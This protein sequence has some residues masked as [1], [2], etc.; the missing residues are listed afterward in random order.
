[1]ADFSSF[2]LGSS[3]EKSK[4]SVEDVQNMIFGQESNFG[5]AKTDVPNYAGAIGPGQILPKTWAGLK[6][7]G[8]IP[9]SYDINVPEHNVAGSKALVADAYNRYGGDADKVL[10][11]YYAGP[12]VI[13]NGEI[14]TNWKDLK[15]PKAPNVGQYIEQ[16][17]SKLEGMGDSFSNFIMGGSTTKSEKT[18]PEQIATQQSMPKS[19]MEASVNANKELQPIA[20]VLPSVASLADVTVGSVL[21]FVGKQATY[22]VGR[23]LGQNPTEAEATSTKVSEFL[24]KPFGKA[25]GAT[26][27]PAYKTEASQQ[28]MN[29]IGENISKGAEWIAQKTGLP[30][31][32]VQNMIGTATIAAGKGVEI[33]AKPVAKAVGTFLKEREIPPSELQSQFE[34]KG[35]ANVGAAQV[36]N[37][38]IL[39]EAINRAQSPDLKAEFQTLKPKEINPVVLERHLEAD[40]LPIPI[41]LTKGQAT[42]D[43]KILSDEINSRAKNPELAYRY[44]EQNAQLIDNI[45]AIKENAAPDVYGTNHVENG[46]TLIDAYKIIDE[47][48]KADINL[49]YEALK[50]AAGG[51]FPIDG[52]AFANNAFK[53]LSKDLKSDFVPPAIEKQLKRF[54]EGEP[55]TF[56]QFESMRTNL[57]AEMRK[58]SRAGDG[59]AEMASSIVRNSLEDLPLSGGAEALKPL[60]DEARA[61]AKNRFDT[62]SQDKAYKAAVNDAVAAD[63]FIQK[64]VV[65]GKKADIDTMVNHLGVDS[66]ARQT[67][68]A[69]IVNWLKSKSGIV[70]ESG[71]FSQAGF[72]KALENIDPKILNIVGPEVNQQ[73]KALGNTAR[74]TQARPKGSYVNESNTFVNQAANLAKSGMEKSA[75]V[76]LGGGVVPVGTIIRE[77]AQKRATSKA[78]KESLKAGAGTKLSDI[79]K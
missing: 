11:E 16:A 29:F 32:D 59:N 45:N 4:Y 71:N 7:K 21:P 3:P 15:N 61:A 39:N 47:A 18:A 25:I 58:A 28:L 22:A 57:A 19:L 33:T 42:Q 26:E 51:Q 63:D 41:R 64:F 70:N 74:L 49:K 24:D 31:N 73:L 75:N 20:N 72:N 17:K 69:G 35:G 60:A 79:G 43:V 55:M 48:K 78:T 52:V 54:Q 12:D 50:N 14:Q 38:T 46:Q 40:T 56:E 9:T 77:T 27:N 76:F 1:M 67:M 30:V 8:L 5:Q 2:I 36:Q 10:A 37:Q 34:A 53:Q 44:N 23:A 6:Q 66:V 65:N 62:L 68:A 13:K